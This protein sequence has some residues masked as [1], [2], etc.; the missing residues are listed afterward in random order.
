MDIYSAGMP[1][2][3]LS[4]VSSLLAKL[5]KERQHHVDS[6]AEID[7]VFGRF[8][9]SPPGP[10]PA[11]RGKGRGSRGKGRGA[12]GMMRVQGVKEALAAALSDSPQSPS[13]LQQ[14]VSKKLGVKVNIAT[15]L[16]MLKKEKRAK[17]VGRGQWVRAG[18]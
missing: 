11:G 16:N 9:A 17:S 3:T 18:S 8:G 14:K 4:T 6:I 1:S 7:A 15:Q 13:E 2:N 10:A 5:R 12:P